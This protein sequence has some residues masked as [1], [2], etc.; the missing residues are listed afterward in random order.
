MLGIHAR[1]VFWKHGVRSGLSVCT[2]RFESWKTDEIHLLKEG[3]KC[4][5]LEYL[6][7]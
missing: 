7:E 3:Q 1:I 5:Q 6:L 4:C 2:V